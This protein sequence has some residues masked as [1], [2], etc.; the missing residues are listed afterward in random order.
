M[1]VRFAEQFVKERFIAHKAGEGI[2]VAQVFEAYLVACETAEI[3]A[4]PSLLLPIRTVYPSVHIGTVLR[5]GVRVM[6]YCGLGP[7]A[8]AL[9]EG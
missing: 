9:V 7:A 5:D 3:E 6:A 2:P 1:S 4:L 8:A